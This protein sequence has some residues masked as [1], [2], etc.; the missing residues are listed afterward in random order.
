[1]NNAWRLAVTQLPRTLLL[2]LIHGVPWILFL[3]LPEVFFRI[4]WIWVIVGGAAGGFLSVAVIKPV[5][6]RLE[7]KTG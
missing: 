3:F 4:F 7:G 5:F 2:L 6:D 1:M